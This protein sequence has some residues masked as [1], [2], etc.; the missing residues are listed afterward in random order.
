MLLEGEKSEVSNLYGAHAYV[1]MLCETKKEKKRP[2][3]IRTGDVFNL[4]YTS[5]VGYT[6]NY[7]LIKLGYTTSTR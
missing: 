3:G 6:A 4:W 7:S 2:C 1:Y 5:L